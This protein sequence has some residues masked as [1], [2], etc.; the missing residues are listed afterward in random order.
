[1]VLVNS[2][3]DKGQKVFNET[4]T[5]GVSR[6]GQIDSFKSD[7]FENV[8]LLYHP[9][10]NLKGLFYVIILD[11]EHFE[12]KKELGS[13]RIDVHYRSSWEDCK[14][15]GKRPDTLSLKSITSLGPI[16]SNVFCINNNTKD[17]RKY[18]NEKL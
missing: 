4:E 18:T 9:V 11:R 15:L 3:K 5:S 14:L 10:E 6:P 16:E 17:R 13:T 8:F 1:M 12:S 7:D 2:E